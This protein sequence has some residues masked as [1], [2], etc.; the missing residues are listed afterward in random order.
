MWKIKI[1]HLL[2]A[3]VNTLLI[4]TDTFYPKH[5]N[6]GNTHGGVGT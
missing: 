6:D 3:E 2:H 1:I 4:G 5:C